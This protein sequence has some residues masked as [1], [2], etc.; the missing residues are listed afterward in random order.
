MKTLIALSAAVLSLAASAANLVLVGDSTLALFAGE[1]TDKEGKTSFDTT[2]PSKAGA[3]RFAELFLAEVRS[4]KLPVTKLF[5]P[6]ETK[7]K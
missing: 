7:K 6:E 3:K 5:K 1:Q 2:H 4:R